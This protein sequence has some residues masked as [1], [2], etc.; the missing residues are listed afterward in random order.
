MRKI[1]NLLRRKYTKTEAISI[2]FSIVAVGV[3]IDILLGRFNIFSI[4]ISIFLIVI[5]TRKLKQKKNSFIAYLLI[6]L[7]AGFL[8]ISLFTSFAFTLIFATLIIYNCYQLFRSSSNKS[9]LSVNIKPNPLESQAYIRTDPYFKNKLIGEYRDFQQ[10]YTLEDINLQ[11][12]F[13]DVSIDLSD[14]VIPLG[15]TVI[16][17]RG[18]IGNIYLNVPS[19]VGISVQMSLLVGKMNLSKDGKT[20][21]NVTQKYQSVDY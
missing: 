5:G 7:G 12:G 21:I 14:T 13:G 11:T 4:A 19:D 15:E 10:S 2:I 17:T 3:V 8:L 1:N 6:I 9:H 16:L 20:A 18:V